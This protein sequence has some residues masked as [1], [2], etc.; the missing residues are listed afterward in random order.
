MG[1]RSAL[2]GS[3]I[4]RTGPASLALGNALTFPVPHVVQAGQGDPP[5]HQSDL[6]PADPCVPVLDG[7]AAHLVPSPV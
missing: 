7:P 4:P 1:A 2:V 5:G 3:S 6:S